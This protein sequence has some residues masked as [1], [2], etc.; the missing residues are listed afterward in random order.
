MREEFI[1][2]HQVKRGKSCNNRHT[3]DNIQI[4]NKGDKDG[5]EEGQ[6]GK[7]EPRGGLQAG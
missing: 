7:D 6:G 2:Y 1:F 5:K 3:N 4:I